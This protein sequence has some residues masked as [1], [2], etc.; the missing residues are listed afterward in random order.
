MPL[1]E[2]HDAAV[3]VGVGIGQEAH[4]IVLLSSGGGVGVLLAA[5]LGVAVDVEASSEV[6]VTRR[7]FCI[8]LSFHRA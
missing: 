3:R 5:V 2:R 1:Q 4:Y 8:R 6:D 7:M